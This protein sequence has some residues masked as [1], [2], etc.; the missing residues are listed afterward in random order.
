MKDHTALINTLRKSFSKDRISL[1]YH[2]V[3]D[4]TFT[5]KLISLAEQDIEKKTKKRMALLISESFQ[6]IV[7]HGDV[8]LGGKNNSIFSI[9]GIGNFLHIFSSN[10]VDKKSKEFLEQQLENINKL[11]KD[12][13]KSYY[14]E[15]LERGTM[16]EKG[17]AGLGL[18]EMARKSERP[19]QKDFKTINEDLFAF[20]M[21]IDLM[22]GDKE[23]NEFEVPPISIKENTV[24]NEL[25]IEHDII[26][27]FKGDFSFEVI[28]PML[29]IMKQNT[30]DGTK[31]SG[32]KIFHTAV[33]LMQ[34][35]SRY[36]KDVEGRKEGIFS[37]NK[38][39]N[40][41]YLCTGNYT[42][43]SSD[44]FMK[45]V[46]HLNSLVKAD[47]DE[48]YKKMLR[49]RLRNEGN[50]AGVGLIDLKRKNPN[51]LQVKYISDGNENYVIVG[52]EIS[53]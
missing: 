52:I 28:S 34:N 3:F 41:Y 49:E 43:G 36:G 40:G 24:L 47:L 31:S 21:Q 12:Q 48:F 19:I 50:H 26:F 9:R 46:Q 11:D 17:G 39:Q 53:F 30:V 45:H 33:E 27:L 4:D 37:L 16:S 38:T 23:G 7:R 5:D 20:Y 14:T 10:L 25:I 29:N 1:N 8:E 51:P 35:V 2:G 6:N 18:L 22:V 44:D 15:V 32:F 13:L 42:N